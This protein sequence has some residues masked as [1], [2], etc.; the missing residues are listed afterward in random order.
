MTATTTEKWIIFLLGSIFVVGART[1]VHMD[2][3][4]AAH[5]FEFMFWI[6]LL[7]LLGM[8]ARAIW[9]KFVKETQNIC[10]RLSAI[11]RAIRETGNVTR[12]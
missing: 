6:G 10:E 2:T 4:I 12:Q 1:G 3:W 9:R 7:G 5:P 11:E 8:W